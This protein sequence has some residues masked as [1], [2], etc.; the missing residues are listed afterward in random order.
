LLAIYAG[1]KDAKIEEPVVR[2]V[3]GKFL[4]TDILNIKKRS[5]FCAASISSTT[6]TDFNERLGTSITGTRK[7]SSNKRNYAWSYNYR[8]AEKSLDCDR[9]T[10]ATSKEITSFPTPM[11]AL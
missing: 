10:N 1:I 11:K 9:G 5:L 4:A 7:R 2:D 3:S 8:Y 6:H